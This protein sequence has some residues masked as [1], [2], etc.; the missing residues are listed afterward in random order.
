MLFYPEFRLSGNPE[1]PREPAESK[2][3]KYKFGL[4]DVRLIFLRVGS[5]GSICLTGLRDYFKLLQK[6]DKGSQES[7]KLLRN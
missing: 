4:S 3:L 7:F 5:E 6:Q 1:F 2:E